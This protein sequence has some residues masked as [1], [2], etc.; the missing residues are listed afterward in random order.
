[1]NTY[2][3]AIDNLFPDDDDQRVAALGR[4]QVF[5]DEPE[6]VFDRICELACNMFNVPIAHISFLDEES[7]L[8]KSSMGL[9]EQVIRVDR[10]MSLCAITVLNG[11]STVIPNALLD[12]RLAGHP[13]VYGEFGLRAY[14]GAP[15]ISNDGYIVGTMCLVSHEVRDFTGHEV[16]LLEGLARIVAE[17][18]ELRL[19]NLEHNN[20]QKFIQDRLMASEARLRCI[21]DTMADGVCI[22][23]E[24]GTTTYIN[25]MAGQ[26][27]GVNLLQM[28]NRSYN[29]PLWINL[30]LDGSVLPIDEHPMYTMLKTAAPVYD[31]EIGVARPEKDTFYISVNAVPLFSDQNELSG[32]VC[33]F[34]DVT[35]RRKLMKEKD[36]FIS[37][38]SHELKTPITSLGASLQLIKKMKDN[39]SPM[40]P[41]LIELANESMER[42]NSLVG[43]LL[44]ANNINI[45]ALRLN[46]KAFSIYEMIDACCRQLRIAG[47]YRLMITGDCSLRMYADQ[48]RISQVVINLINN[49]VKYAPESKVIEINISTQDGMAKI[50]VADQ[51]EGI[52][53]E[54]IP[55]LFDRYYRA[56]YKSLHYSGLGLGLYISADIIRRHGG[57]IGVESVPG[58]GACFWFTAPLSDQ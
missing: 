23:D 12:E 33:T 30:R 29:D 39:L 52:D 35:A 15:I 31:R 28:Q 55:Y 42:L 25:Q 37:I 21:L 11:S 10:S 57:E 18:L 19:E 20:R 16:S 44:D 47:E 13:Y 27:F 41:K 50:S 40:V 53:I 48:E 26:I 32:G 56:D 22:V 5:N 46:S 36:D 14:A 24:N 58:Q 45:G 43:N 3:H 8:V 17:Q 51:G 54:K 7:E 1:M 9:G 38:A 49:A 34:I 2:K 4:Y 6:P